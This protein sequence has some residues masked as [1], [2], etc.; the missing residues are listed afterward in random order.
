LER[1]VGEYGGPDDRFAVRS[2]AASEDSVRHSF[3]GQ[4]ESFV[5]VPAADVA[6]RVADVWR[7]GFAERVYAYRRE[8]GLAGPPEAPA[9]LVQRMVPADVSGVAFS[10]D[11]VGGGRDVA[12]VAAVYGL[13]TLLVDGEG[14]ADTYRVDR[15]GTVIERTVVR[16]TTAHVAP[17]GTSDGV[18]TVAVSAEDEDRAALDDS[19]VAAVA[20]LARHC[21]DHFGRP[22]DIEWCIRAGELFLL[23]SR[24][25]TS[26]F[27]LPE[28]DG[29]LNIWDNSNIA[30]SYG[31][32]TTPLTFSFARNAYEGVYRQLA[33]TF[34]VPRRRV[35]ENTALFANM[36]GL[37]RGRVYYNLLNWYR[38]IAMLPGYTSN[39][40]FME[41][42]MGVKES[43]PPELVPSSSEAGFVG[44]AVDRLHLASAVVGFSSQ[45]FTLRWKMK[46]FYRR[47][48]SALDMRGRS[49]A[50]MRADELVAEYRRLESRLLAR[51]DAP[52]IN[53]FYTMI[54]YGVLRKLCAS[55]CGDDAG[56]LQNDL[57]CGSGG[58][59]STEPARRMREMAAIAAGDPKLAQGLRN[60]DAATIHRL[61]A[62]NSDFRTRY[63][64]YLEKFGER[65]YDELKLESPTLHDDPLMLLRAVGQ[66]ARQP[67]PAPGG[68]GEAAERRIRMDAEARVA[69]ALSS[70]PLRRQIF[71]WVLRNARDRVR[72]RENLRLERT[73]LFGRVRR[74][75]VELGRRFY[76][77]DLLDAPRDVL[78]LALGVII[79][80][81]EGT[82]TCTNLRALARLR[83]E[84]FELFAEAEP[85]DDRFETRG[86]V[87]AGNTFRSNLPPVQ[88]DGDVRTGI[89]C[90]PGRVSGRARVVR[91]P[92]RAALEQGDI[93]VA[94]RT[95]PSW[96]MLFPFAAG[97][98]VERG[99][100]LSHSAIVAREMGIPAVVSVGGVMSWLSDGD[101][102]E[103][104]G[105]S[106]VVR[107]VD[108]A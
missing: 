72:G 95:D 33:R 47:L 23:Q 27:D 43:L 65:C 74:I 51:W 14:D 10:A 36:L 1:L 105:T 99:S 37:V 29:A 25:I 13:G 107:R 45:Y 66:M 8:H 21:A 30:E 62:R 90:C 60:A 48:E 61:A 91:D 40:A 59:I 82:A 26:L 57:L 71:G 24:P 2:S 20:D 76:E 34:G 63:E 5:F 94:E 4:L 101:R 88:R 83:R 42:M 96:I 92:R 16:K 97:L 53:D 49:L 32:V 56:T 52:L 50:A 17:E 22:Q 11:P 55:W 77:R 35:E 68:S 102:V 58:M 86:M 93:L 3:A 64:S 15:S 84:E 6:R 103:L 41:Q 38:Y 12:V 31:G 106:G 69:R 85:P 46:H 7:S 89:G 39:R 78:Y 28:P 100:L 79:G 67:D 87:Y 81:V 19:S 75:F 108:A 73:R 98:V 70:R 54:F 44:R 18:E 80:F 9:V 104:D